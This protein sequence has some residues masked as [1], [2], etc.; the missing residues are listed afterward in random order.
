MP[1]TSLSLDD[2]IRAI[3]AR[4]AARRMGAKTKGPEA[5]TKWGTTSNPLP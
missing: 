5:S 4:L 3:D 2:P 1:P